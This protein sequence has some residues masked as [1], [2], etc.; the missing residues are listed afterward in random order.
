MKKPISAVQISFVL[1]SIVSLPAFADGAA[2]YNKVCVACHG[3]GVSG[4]PKIAD[5]AAWAP[6]IAEGQSVLTAHAYVGLGAMPPK[7]GKPDL[8]VQ[9]FADAV[10]Y[11]TSKAGANWK[12]PDAK[13]LAAINTEI[14]KRK[15]ELASKPAKK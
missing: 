13:A 14:A 9:D 10:V 3:T 12:S 4:A 15:K 6:R 2:T 1:L 11:M 7:G 5:K 8:S